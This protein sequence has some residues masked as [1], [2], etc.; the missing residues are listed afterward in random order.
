MNLVF[1]G[2]GRFLMVMVQI[3]FHFLAIKMEIQYF[4]LVQT[5]K[6]GYLNAVNIL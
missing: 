6:I 2:Y 3:V 1:S 5:I 4:L